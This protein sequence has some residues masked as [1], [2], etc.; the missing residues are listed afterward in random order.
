MLITFLLLLIVIT[1]YYL[2]L[3]VITCYYLL[4]FL[5]LLIFKYIIQYY[6]YI[7]NILYNILNILKHKKYGG[8]V[9]F[10][11]KLDKVVNAKSTSKTLIKT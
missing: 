1:C 3:L 11:A 4:L 5:L 6:K 10:K 7:L 2:L 9:S 8:L